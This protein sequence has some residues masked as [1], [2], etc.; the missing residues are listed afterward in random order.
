MAE[1][2]KESREWY[3][4]YN[5]GMEA[6]V[7]KENGVAVTDPAPVPSV[8]RPRR[9]RTQ[10]ERNHKMVNITLPPEIIEELDA[11]AKRELRSRSNMVAYLV[12]EGLRRRQ[13]A[14]GETMAND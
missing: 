5:A 12:R 3:L 7:R 1:Q 10:A 6:R 13:G 2:P 11:L 4:G 14:Q 9:R 8:Y